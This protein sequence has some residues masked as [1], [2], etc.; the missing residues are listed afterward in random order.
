MII[1]L[2][3]QFTLEQE[4]RNELTIILERF[5]ILPQNINNIILELRK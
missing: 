5:D 3:Q 2:E 1:S 4:I